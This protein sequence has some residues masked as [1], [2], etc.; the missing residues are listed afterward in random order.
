[1]APKSMIPG[2]AVMP[3]NPSLKISADTS[4]CCPAA[5]TLRVTLGADKNL[6]PTSRREQTGHQLLLGPHAARP[7][8]KTRVSWPL[9]CCHINSYTIHAVLLQLANYFYLAPSMEYAYTIQVSLSF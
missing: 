9:P 3:L 8:E 1:M 7:R 2:L 4:G 5:L 6:W